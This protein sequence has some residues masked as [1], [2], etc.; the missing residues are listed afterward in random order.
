MTVRYI[1]ILLVL[2]ISSSMTEE[3][4]ISYEMSFEELSKVQVSLLSTFE[5]EQLEAASNVYILNNVDAFKLDLRYT[6]DY[7][8]T[9]PGVVALQNRAGSA[10]IMTR[11]ISNSVP[12]G[13][14]NLWD[15][16]D[17]NSLSFNNSQYFVSNIDL[18]TLD[19]VQFAKGPAS[20]IYG[21]DA[22]LGAA[23]YESYTSYDNEFITS[24]ETSTD[25]FQ[26]FAFKGS[27]NLDEIHHLNFAFAYSQL[28]DKTIPIEFLSGSERINI[29]SEQ[30]T[31]TF[32]SVVKLHS[33]DRQDL[34][35]E[36]AYY[37]NYW[38]NNI[39]IN[40][41]LENSLPSSF[42]D[43][44]VEDN[45]TLFQM[46]RFFSSYEIDHLSS[47][48]TTSYFWNFDS[49]RFFHGPG[50][51]L[52]RED[53]DENTFGNQITYKRQLPSLKTQLAL[54]YAFRRQEIKGSDLEFFDR[55]TSSVIFTDD[56]ITERTTHSL[57]LDGKTYIYKDLLSLSYGYRLDYFKTYD[58]QKTPRVGLVW[59]IDDSSALKWIYSEGFRPPS[60]LV[61]EIASFVNPEKV[62][63]YEMIYS[64]FAKNYRF[65]ITAF[66]L[67]YDDG[68]VPGTGN[69]NS[70]DNFGLELSSNYKFGQWFAD[71]STSFVESQNQGG[72][73]NNDTF[74]SIIINTGLGYQ[75]P[76]Q[77]YLIY[78]KSRLLNDMDSTRNSKEK[79]NTFFQV[80]LHIEY[81]MNTKAKLWFNIKNLLARNNYLPS[82]T[83]NINGVLSQEPAASI[84]VS[85][86]F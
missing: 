47:I 22:H 23:S 85:Y 10:V 36:L 58:L 77:K 1:S 78:L 81:R 24:F 59:K 71:L 28:D 38:N 60:G 26:K 48:E 19:R 31:D 40:P 8:N 18:F 70:T 2:L 51:L 39:T 11:G 7:F 76:S 52:D 56:T 3:Q 21:A 65:D 16:V 14:A 63:T 53:L 25:N 33:D 72:L 12:R 42:F 55:N 6:D 75:F 5:E 37:L 9:L 43:I 82:A 54:S 74:P 86:S 46:L 17:I 67:D 68:I 79:L 66:F 62:K 15:G 13:I 30:K 61:E 83:Q 73:E 34:Y 80:D 44:N 49:Q 84:G 4:A 45:N 27:Q 57:F 41:A 20:S 69:V 32:T 29:N 64:H 35:Y 50:S